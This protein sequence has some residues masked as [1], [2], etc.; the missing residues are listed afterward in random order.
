MNI[1]DKA[2]LWVIFIVFL[3]GG[4][5]S[6]YPYFGA[7]GLGMG[8]VFTGS[9]ND[10]GAIYQNPAVLAR[11]KKHVILIEGF[12]GK[13][14]LKDVAGNN[15]STNLE[16][17]PYDNFIFPTNFVIACSL[18]KWGVGF[19]YNKPT[20]YL[21]NRDCYPFSQ[22]Y[23]FNQRIIKEITLGSG[24]KLGSRI[25]TGGHV[26]IS[27]KTWYYPLVSP[28]PEFPH[29]ICW[30]EMVVKI[31]MVYQIAPSITFSWVFQPY[32]KIISGIESHKG[33]NVYD[34][35]LKSWMSQLRNSFYIL[36]I[37]YSVSNRLLAAISIKNV[38]WSNSEIDIQLHT[39]LEYAIISKKVLF[40]IG[41]Y[42]IFL[43]A[44]YTRPADIEHPLVIHNIGDEYKFMTFGLG[45]N[46]HP[47]T[48]D[49]AVR[50]NFI[51]QNS[52]TQRNDIVIG[53]SYG[54]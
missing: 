47:I 34:D 48:I 16:K 50:N 49:I 25:L 21:Y 51:S 52:S 53:L 29:A 4:F 23:L 20:V 27:D 18:D 44:L 1:R 41:G 43:P 24:V 2:T 26:S 19:S 17:Y 22:F 33:K 40:R 5:L 8:G 31:G 36:S 28:I 6:G 15:F 54:F 7:R 9:T 12:Y 38:R 46:L 14:W 39:G 37:D 11:I 30:K 3:K 35:S 45:F 13:G 10:V 32:G 42:N